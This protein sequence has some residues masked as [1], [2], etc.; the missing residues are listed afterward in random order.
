MLEPYKLK[1]R[2]LLVAA[3]AQRGSRGEQKPGCFLSVITTL[4]QCKLKSATPVCTAFLIESGSF[5]SN[6]CFEL[7]LLSLGSLTISEL[8]MI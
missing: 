2:I 3:E 5:C 6:N 8:E 7:M 4:V 1:Y